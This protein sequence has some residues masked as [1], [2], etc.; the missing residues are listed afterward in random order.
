MILLRPQRRRWLSK[1]WQNGS[2][3]DRPELPTVWP[4]RNE[5]SRNLERIV[6]CNGP[7]REGPFARHV[8]QPVK[9]RSRHNFVMKN[10][11]VQVSDGSQMHEVRKMAELKTMTW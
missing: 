11:Y 2:P 5:S 3:T 7:F 4:S 6:R 9:E 8:D 1:T 10:D